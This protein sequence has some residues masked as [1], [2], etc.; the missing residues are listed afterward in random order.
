M[1]RT[2]PSKKIERDRDE[3]RQATRPSTE[4]GRL[5][6]QPSASAVTEPEPTRDASGTGGASGGLNS[7]VNGVAGAALDRPPKGRPRRKPALPRAAREG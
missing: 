7:S 6:P 2:E 3:A 4:D 5:G 1:K